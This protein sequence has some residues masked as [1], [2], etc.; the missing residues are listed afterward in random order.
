MVAGLAGAATIPAFRAMRTLRALR[1][2]RAVSRWE[3]MRVST[4]VSADPASSS[5]QC[6]TTLCAA[7][8]LCQQ[9]SFINFLQQMF[10]PTHITAH[11][12]LM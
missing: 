11:T 12:E 6:C 8:R 10:V 3:G 7:S 5:T 9:W 1:P 2:L 4:C